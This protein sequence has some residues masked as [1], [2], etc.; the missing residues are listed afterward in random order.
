MCSC[1]WLS[2]SWGQW[3]RQ[4]PVLGH[5]SVLAGDPQDT[6]VNSTTKI[7]TRQH[8]PIWKVFYAVSVWEQFQELLWINVDFWFLLYIL[9]SAT[10]DVSLKGWWFQLKFKKKEKKKKGSRDLQPRKSLLTVNPLFC[11]CRRTCSS[12]TNTGDEQTLTHTHRGMDVPAIRCGG[13]GDELW[14]RRLQG[15]GLAP[16]RGCRQLL[17]RGKGKVRIR[18]Q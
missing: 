18:K 11:L 13:T 12:P 10:V 14:F 9:S 8:L 2:H 5:T 16:S 1:G 3:H 4:D 15:P 6:W 17:L 7:L